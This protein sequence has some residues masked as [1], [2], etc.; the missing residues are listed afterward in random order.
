[1]L[2]PMKRYLKLKKE[3]AKLMLNGDVER[4]LHKLRELALTKPVVA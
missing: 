4:Y 1:M 3:A 2:T